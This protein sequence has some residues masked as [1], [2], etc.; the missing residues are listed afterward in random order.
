MPQ[1]LPATDYFRFCPGE[2]HI[3]ISNAICRGRRNASYP[4][5][6]GC[7]FNDDERAAAPA[8]GVN[9][10]SRTA[11]DVESVFSAVDVRGTVPAPLSDDVAWRIGHAAAQYLRG[12]LSGSQRA[13]PN[14]RAM[15]VGRDGRAH[16]A[17]L[18][19]ALIEGIRSAG[20][21]VIN[22]GSID[23]P[24]LYFAVNHYGACGGVQTTASHR[25]AHYNGFIICGPRAISINVE[26]GLAAI[27]D[28]AARVPKHQTGTT[29]RLTDG[30]LTKHYR[31]F[32]LRFL[33]GAP[34]LVRPISVVIDASNGMIG[35]VAPAIFGKI[36]NL[37]IIPL[38]FDATGPFAHVPDPTR[39][40][41]LSDLRRAVKQHKADF[42]VCFDGDGDRCAF[43]DERG[44]TIGGDL[45][46][47]LLARSII[48][49]EP[50]A[51]IV[52]DLRCSR[53]V[54]E[55]VDRV[56]GRAVRERVGRPFIIK[57]MVEHNAVLGVELSGHYYFRD[58]FFN[59]SG[60]VAFAHVINILVATGRK[61]GD[62]VKSIQ[63]YRASGE[64]GFKCPD[65]DVTF[66]ELRRVFADAR[67]DP[68]DGL[69]FEYPDWWFNVRASRSTPVLR[70][71]LEARTKKQVEEK[72]AE[73][74]PLLG[75]REK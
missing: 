37:K 38:H 52:H 1:T 11:T 16:S 18:Q 12:K 47:A 46:G 26:T 70:L 3:K 31:E 43:V 27:R 50:G 65:R 32:V 40:S 4:K 25:P 57:S 21:D 69:T 8:V 71:N 39:P 51:G 34:A 49:K 29:A 64:V 35:R 45:I 20:M 62:L 48:E 14:S 63:R 19:A 23:T 74:S 36:D 22:V 75:V 2:E 55:E 15:I 42:G 30:D 7:Q 58:A 68:L 41:A 5:C 56:G 13:D 61:L 73:L 44:Q 72:L 9:T 59:D 53:V 24:Q 6:H 33:R 60:L 17:V 28:I 67:V 54:P 10:R 66:K